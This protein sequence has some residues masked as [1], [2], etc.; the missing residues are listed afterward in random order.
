MRKLLLICL[1]AFGITFCGCKSTTYYTSIRTYGENL[2][3]LIDSY[4]DKGFKLSG[5]HSNVTKDS[6]ATYVNAGYGIFLPVYNHRDYK[7]ELEYKFMDS[8]GNNVKVNLEYQ[9]YPIRDNGDYEIVHSRVCGCETNN[10]NFYEDLCKN[11]NLI[12][13]NN[14]PKSDILV[15]DKTSTAIAAAIVLPLFIVTGWYLMK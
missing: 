2:N 3:N 8:V 11:E 13:F 1:I 10:P 15:I 12:T 4:E 7:Y 5:E 9:I 6:D 14:L